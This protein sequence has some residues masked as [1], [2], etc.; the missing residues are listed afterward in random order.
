V[1]RNYPKILRNRKRGIER[2]LD[3]KKAWGN[4]P[5]PMMSAS[6]IHYE[7]ADR[8][9]AVN[10]AGIGAIHMMVDRI[11]LRGEI[12]ARLHLLK[13]HLP[14]H[15][16][17][18]VLN[19]SYNAMLDGVRLQDIELRRND[20]AFLDG[21]G[22]ERI[23]DPTTSGD[24]TRR[25]GRDDILELMEAINS[26]RQRVWKA[27]GG[28]FLEEAFIDTDGTIAPTLGECK[29]GMAL[30]YKGVWGYAPLTVSLANS[31]EV[32]YLV[33]RPGNA[34]SHEGCVEWMDRAIAVVR[35]F[36]GRITLRGDTDFTLTGELDRWDGEGIHFIFGMDAHRK[37]VGLAE[38][39]PEREWQP[40]PRLPRYEMA[41]RP[42]R[43]G[44]R[45]KESIV[46]FKGYENK[47][48]VGE[49]VAEIEYQPTKCRRPFRL[50][51][52]RK[53][54]SVQQ[55]E[56]ALFDEV[57]YFFYL[58]NREDYSAE[59]VV[60][61]ANGRCHQENV[62][63]QLKN[64]V[65]AMRMPVDDLLSNWAYM[66][67]TALAWNLKA[68]FGLLMPDRQRGAEIVRMEF[69]RFLH[70]LILLPAQI[71]RTGRR[72]IYRIMAYNGWVKDLF[73]AWERLRC[74]WVT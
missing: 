66:V 31:N 64:G 5:A 32:L 26:T 68:W 44:E 40:L 3:P 34:V 24:F 18:H 6:N 71:V 45:V 69:R 30:S 21:L 56:Q 39:L 28:G 33:N 55:G 11:G 25:F 53:N 73:A 36:A 1:N 19:L 60:S 54:I 57:R 42:R 50:I 35:P 59:E 17:D 9:R 12:D 15:E 70:A 13:R 8:S 7:M 22:A 41:T 37:V 43:K 74:L 27:Q 20:E 58:T 23:P 51:I 63:E 47:V 67:M 14:Y 52:V 48:L 61:L 4:Q 62:I 2:R 16:S 72:I 46:R 10:C 49:S 38:T 29:G 65:N